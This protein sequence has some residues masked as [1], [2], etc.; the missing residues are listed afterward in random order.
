M[1]YI[2]IYGHMTLLVKKSSSVAFKQ[3]YLHASVNLQC[4]RWGLS[5]SGVVADFET[6]DYF[7]YGARYVSANHFQLFTLKVLRS[8]T[9]FNQNLLEICKYIYFLRHCE[10]V[11]CFV[12]SI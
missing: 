4:L 6:L 8:D 9:L 5:N 11:V 10:A 3:H 12:Y 7:C 1:S 2:H